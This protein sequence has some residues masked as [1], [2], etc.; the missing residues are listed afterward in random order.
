MRRERHHGPMLA[1]RARMMRNLALATIVMAASLTGCGPRG[2]KASVS[3]P[4][5]MVLDGDGLVLT[6][7]SRQTRLGSLVRVAVDTWT[8]T[9]LAGG[10]ATL[11]VK[12]VLAAD[13]TS[14]YFFATSK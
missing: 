7:V 12:D 2:F 9:T 13:A 1:R 5:E 8:V 11:N 6:S 14:F 3:S 4:G 10:D